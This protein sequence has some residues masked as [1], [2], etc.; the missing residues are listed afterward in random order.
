MS[1]L[2]LQRKNSYSFFAE[3]TRYLIKSI[4]IKPSLAMSEH[5]DLCW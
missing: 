3:F 4:I 1:S 5:R 2:I